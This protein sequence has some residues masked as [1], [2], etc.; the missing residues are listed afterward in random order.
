M[1]FLNFSY[2]CGS[3]LPSWIRIR[4]P[5]TDPDPLTNRDPDTQPCLADMAMMHTH[6]WC[7]S[8]TKQTWPLAMVHK[9][10]RGKG[11]LDHN[12]WFEKAANDQQRATRNSAEALNL[13]VNQC[14]GSGSGTGIRCLF[15]PSIRDL[16]S[17]I[18]FF[19]IPDPKAI[20]LRA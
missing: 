19:R 15:D 12:C 8:L 7:I 4:I 2:F 17:G 10:M 5:N 20:F 1:K 11:Q 6:S 13:R 14:C 3:F 9:I 18:G 16:G